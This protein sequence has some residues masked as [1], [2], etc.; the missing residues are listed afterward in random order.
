MR[1]DG[2]RFEAFLREFEPTIAALGKA[3]VARLRKRLPSADVMIYDNYNFLV[4]G[5]SPDGRASN[6]VLSVA[7]GARGA[8]RCF[9]QGAALSDPHH[10]LRGCV[11]RNIRLTSA[12][13]STDP[14]SPC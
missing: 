1:T 2:K 11:A 3:A 13:T 4:A 14:R 7:L 5:F 12:K 6:A 10:I 8:K 9:L